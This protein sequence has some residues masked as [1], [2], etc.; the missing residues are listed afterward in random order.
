MPLRPNQRIL[1]MR[2]HC[3]VNKVVAAFY[4]SWLNNKAKY[5]VKKIG[6]N[7]RHPARY[8]PSLAII[9]ADNLAG[10]TNNFGD[11]IYREA[12]CL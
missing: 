1:Y 5:R 11:P 3:A 8:F 10:P 4:F 2:P 12:I 7:S 9:P 6:R